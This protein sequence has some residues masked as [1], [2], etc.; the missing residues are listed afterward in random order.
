MNAPPVT[1]AADLPAAAKSRAVAVV[2]RE[3]ASADG[4][5]GRAD[6]RKAV[7]PVYPRGTKLALGQTPTS[8][9]YGGC[10]GE[11]QATVSRDGSRLL[12]ASYF[13]DGG[14]SASHLVPIPQGACE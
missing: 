5:A 10:F 13:D 6:V 11:P 9:K 4:Q 12:F 3:A 2:S 8:A 1:P 14:G 7:E